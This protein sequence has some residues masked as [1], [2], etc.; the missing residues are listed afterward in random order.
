MGH[1]VQPFRVTKI[2]YKKLMSGDTT[3]RDAIGQFRTSS[4]VNI[5]EQVINPIDSIHQGANVPFSE[6]Y[7]GRKQ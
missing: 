3:R 4:N 7:S 2:R 5:L 1:P 6:A